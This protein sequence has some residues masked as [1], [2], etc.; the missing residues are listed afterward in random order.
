MRTTNT[1]EQKATKDWPKADLSQ[2]KMSQHASREL[3]VILKPLSSNHALTSQTSSALIR[4]QKRVLKH[5]D[6][7]HM[8]VSYYQIFEN[9]RKTR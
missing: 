1:I 7:M 6:T 2:Y 8:C 3:I 9:G 5:K 4:N